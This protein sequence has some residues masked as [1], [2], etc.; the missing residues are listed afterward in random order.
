MVP[1]TNA[2]TLVGPTASRGPAE[3]QDMALLT[4]AK[5]PA[6]GGGPNARDAGL[7]RGRGKRWW[8]S[9]GCM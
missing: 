7:L 5:S 1:R 6:V 8:L 4:A 2:T 9:T 3:E